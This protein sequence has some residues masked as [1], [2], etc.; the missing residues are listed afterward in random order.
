MGEAE[1]TQVAEQEP[2]IRPSFN[3]AVRIEARPDRL[4]ADA[5]VMLMRE[6]MERTG[7]ID[8]LEAH[9]DDSRKSDQVTYSMSELLRT[10]LALLAQ[11]WTSAAAADHLREDPALRLSVSDR[12][13]DM[14]LRAPSTPRTPD[15]L[16]SRRRYAR[17]TLDVDSLPIEVHGQQAGSAYNGYF[18]TRCYHPLILGAAEHGHLFG[19]ILRPGNANTAE[20]AATILRDYL[21]WIENHLAWEVIV[22]GDAGFPADAL[23]AVLEQR[24]RPTQYVFRIRNYTPLRQMARP[25]VAGYLQDLRERPDEVRQEPFRAYELH[26]QGTKWKRA[27]RVVLV[28]VPPEDGQLL[29]R[30][31]YLITNF[32]AATMPAAKLLK[33]YR[34]RGTYEQQLGDFMNTL[35]PHLSSTTRPKSHYRGD[36][37]APYARTTRDAFDTNQAILSLNVLAHNVL[38]MGRRIAERAQ[39]RHGRPRTYGRS[40]PAMSLHTFRE[41]YL[42]VPARITLHSRRVWISISQSTADLWNKWWQYIERLGVVSVVN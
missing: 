2:N 1:T 36:A 31:F 27:R 14:P 21:G 29:P 9:F 23:L 38:N 37:P 30:S 10:Q 25:Y 34:Q 12:R 7:L 15:G 11:G 28:I 42:K 22:R 6:V 33:L 16:A 19:A 18:G 39:T 40:S 4:T 3:R 17:L 41:H 13:Q 5:G 20:G 35:A 8:W 32:S 24:L 26:S